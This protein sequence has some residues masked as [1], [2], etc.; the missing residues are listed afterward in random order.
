MNFLPKGL[1]RGLQLI[2]D[3]FKF[4]LAAVSVLLD[5]NNADM[6]KDALQ[7]ASQWHKETTGK[8]LFEGGLL[9]QKINLNTFALLIGADPFQTSRVML[10]TLFLKYPNWQKTPLKTDKLAI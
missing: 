5:T 6:L 7:V 1:T 2:A 3:F 10:Q 9:L 8:T 4:L